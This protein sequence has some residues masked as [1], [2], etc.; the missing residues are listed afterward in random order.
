MSININL[1][2]S[3]VIPDEADRPVA[4]SISGDL[5]LAQLDAFLK[6]L[7][8]TLSTEKTAGK[9]DE[10]LSKVLALLKEKQNPALEIEITSVLNPQTNSLTYKFRVKT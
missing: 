1:D 4:G 6:T 5:R 9:F 10:F 2:G 7:N 8:N 3:Y